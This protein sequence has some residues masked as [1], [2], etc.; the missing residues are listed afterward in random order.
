MTSFMRGAGSDTLFGESGNDTLGGDNNDALWFRGFKRPNFGTGDDLLDG[1]DG[2]DWLLGGFN[3]LTLA[4]QD[5]GRDTL[6]GG[7]GGDVLDARGGDDTLTDR[8]PKDVVPVENVLSGKASRPVAYKFMLH[9]YVGVGMHAY[10]LNIPKGIGR[11]SDSPAIYSDNKRRN[12]I[13]LRANKPR[14]FTLA[15]VFRTLSLSLG[16]WNVGPYIATAK[17]PLTITVNGKRIAQFGDY[18]IRG[19]DIVEVHFNHDEDTD[20]GGGHHS[21]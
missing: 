2:D 7:T 1:G 13:H 6:A 8:G 11:F 15:E 9:V 5:N 19:N 10:E 4:G 14:K 18:V 3:S 16:R 17:L 12:V 20:G 21:H